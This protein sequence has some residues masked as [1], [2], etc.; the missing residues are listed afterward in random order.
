MSVTSA[1]QTEADFTAPITGDIEK[2][3]AYNGIAEVPAK[4]NN[5]IHLPRIAALLLTVLLPPSLFRI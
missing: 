4:N 2:D 5:V 1:E 3:V